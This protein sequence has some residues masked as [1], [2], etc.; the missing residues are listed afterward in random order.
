MQGDEFRFG[1][2]SMAALEE[3]GNIAKPVCP[4]ASQ[5]KL[6]DA[7]TKALGFSGPFLLKV[8]LSVFVL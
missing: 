3:S 1:A 6:N 5:C 8:S 2:I 7:S 4:F